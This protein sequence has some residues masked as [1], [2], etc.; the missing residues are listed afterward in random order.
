[1]KLQLNHFAPTSPIDDMEMTCEETTGNSFWETLKV[2]S[3]NRHFMLLDVVYNWFSVEN[4]IL[5]G[6]Y[7]TAAAT[8]IKIEMQ[9][10]AFFQYHQR[11]SIAVF[12]YVFGYIYICVY[13]LSRSRPS[14]FC[15][16]ILHVEGV[17]SSP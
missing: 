1:M 17:F 10:T 16:F 14:N 3:L 13:S 12:V 2:I 5:G 7:M 8:E 6:C 4:D 9:H 15:R 11:S